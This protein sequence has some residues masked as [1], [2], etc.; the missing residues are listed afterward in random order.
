MLGAPFW[1]LIAVVLVF[2]PGV[3]S[4][5]ESES[6]PC[7]WYFKDELAPDYVKGVFKLAPQATVAVCSSPR[8]QTY[9][10]SGPFKGKMDVCA[11]SMLPVVFDKTAQRWVYDPAITVFQEAQKFMRI[12]PQ[13]C[14]LPNEGGY[15][16]VLGFSDGMFSEMVRALDEIKA[17]PRRLDESLSP[18]AAAQPGT[19]RFRS[20][21][22]ELRAKGT[23]D[24]LYLSGLS[25]IWGRN[26]SRGLT[27]MMSLE[28][29]DQPE[30]GWMIY[31]DIFPGG[32]RILSLSQPIP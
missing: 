3:S 27:L 26:Q 5:H 16:R 4:G 13:S 31:G 25:I 9:I 22:K 21:L 20:V 19:A 7:R 14:P 32:F 2:L 11:F 18:E 8:A 23:S 10:I 1:M 12:S 28:N 6:S 30:Q 29:P 24:H 17:S 15:T